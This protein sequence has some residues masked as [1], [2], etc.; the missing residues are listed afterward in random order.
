MLSVKCFGTW[1]LID[2]VYNSIRKARNSK[3]DK[4]LLSAA[5]GHKQCA[6]CLH[7]F[8]FPEGSSNPDGFYEFLCQNPGFKSRLE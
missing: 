7:P 4:S 1:L 3:T 6:I 8:P 5:L 2:Q